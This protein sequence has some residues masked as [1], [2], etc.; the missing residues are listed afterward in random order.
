[1]RSKIPALALLLSAGCHSS[2][3]SDPAPLPPVAF[4]LDLAALRV[5][6]TGDL[7]L[8]AAS[9]E[10]QG[11]D[12]DGDGDRTGVVL[13]VLD[14]EI[15]GLTNTG[16]ALPP[17]SLRDEVP[18]RPV[19][20]CVDALGA[21]LVSEA[22]TGADL[23]QDGVPDD[24]A[25]WIFNGRTGALRPMPFAHSTLQLGGDLAAFVGLDAVG[26]GRLHV[27]DARDASLTT[28]PVEPSALL[29]VND[30][31]VAFTRDE[32]GVSD[33]N[34]DGDVTDHSVLHLYDADTRRVVNASFAIRPFSLRIEAGFAGFIASEGENGGLDLD[35]DGDADDPVFVAVDAR[36]GLTRIPGF[37]LS[38]F[39]EVFVESSDSDP[40]SFLAS[41]SERDLDRNGDG[42][43]L[44]L[45]LVR[46]DPR[47]DRILDTGL[48]VGLA[49]PLP[50]AG[51]SVQSPSWIGASV[52]EAAQ[53]GADLDGDGR[54]ESAIPHVVD[55]RTGRR[56]NL[57]FRGFWLAALEERLLGLR[58]EDRGGPSLEAELFAW[59]PRARAVHM[60]GMDVR[61]VLGS[62]GENA[63]VT[64]AE[65]AEDLNGDGDT[66]DFVL[67]L[68]EGATGTVRSLRL[69]TSTFEGSLAP[70]RR[71]A[72]LVSEQAQGR[73]LNGDGDTLDQVLHVI[74][75]DPPL[76]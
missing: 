68:Y 17:G 48:A 76:A 32:A 2:S 45:V 14:M 51:P 19:A 44:D 3:D 46:Y 69:A 1:M 75:L 73:D 50:G 49:G 41:A 66:E 60:T 64:L 52:S 4:D 31:I 53:G 7:R 56:V 55:A 63:L 36:T 13:H 21:F 43:L 25:T 8:V 62:S 54:T 5:F 12:L 23:D 38:F 72:V 30:G 57:G 18:P 20:A 22:E 58:L 47:S 65:G 59:D 74:W 39:G 26:D 34:A 28:L 61:N 10:A 11:A 15:L 67:G 9:E 40:A 71:A 16:L 29:D 35:G 33:L 70:V 6:G 37:E 42:D 24:V 27:F